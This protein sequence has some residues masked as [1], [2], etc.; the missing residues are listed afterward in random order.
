MGLTKFPNGVSSYGVPILGGG[1]IVTTGSIF[2]VDS[3]TGSNSYSGS[4]PD[5]PVATIDH[6]VNLCTANKG[7]YVV[8]MPNH[9]ETLSDTVDCDVDVAGVTVLGLG[10]GDNMPRIAYPSTGSIFSVGAS[11]VTIANINFRAGI[12]DVVI[13]LDIEDASD[14]TRVLGCRFDSGTPGTFEFLISIANQNDANNT[15]IKDVYINM[16]LGDAVHGIKF[17]DD[18]DDSAVVNC[19]IEGDFTTANIGGTGT[20]STNLLIKG[21]LLISGGAGDIGIVAVIVMLTNT[22][23]VV[24]DN[25]FFGN[26]ASAAAYHTADKMFFGNN[27][28]GDEVGATNCS[29]SASDGT[30]ALGSITQSSD[31]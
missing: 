24:V 17:V 14:Y 25:T 13:G 30:V 31:G 6:A 15:L 7:D 11:N 21:N 3:V 4:D 8:V 1:S 5:N 2:F 10:S 9:V 27:Q 16:G 28:Y 19:H 18:S 26:L 23:G 29:T 20:L 12:A 22:T